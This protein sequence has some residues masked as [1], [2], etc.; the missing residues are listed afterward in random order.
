MKRIYISLRC[1]IFS[2]LTSGSSCSSSSLGCF[3][4]EDFNTGVIFFASAIGV[5]CDTFLEAT[6][7]TSYYNFIYM[8]NNMSF[9]LTKKIAL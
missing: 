2:L 4:G 6:E 9:Y 3:L 5:S 7:L 1:I 8:Y